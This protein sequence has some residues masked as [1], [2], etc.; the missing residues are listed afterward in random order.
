[1]K[2]NK[3]IFSIKSKVCVITGG[4]GGIGLALSKAINQNDGKLIII[5][6]IIKKN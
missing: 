6:K 2:K 5:D 4:C 1:M 3:N